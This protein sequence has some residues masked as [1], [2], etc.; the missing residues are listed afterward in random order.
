ML[1]ANTCIRYLN[2][3]SLAVVR[4]VAATPP[5]EVCL[6]SVVKGEIWYGARRSAD[7]EGNRTRQ[8]AFFAQ[9]ITLP[10]DD[11]AAEQYS[12]LRA[13]LAVRGTPI[14]PNDMMIAAIALA[15]ALTLVTHNTTEFSRVRGLKLDDW[16]L[17]A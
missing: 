1:D 6:C 7:P 13:D 9:F 4:R 10:Y 5:H 2:G 11:L 15:H 3:R 14:G 8:D 12:A 16:E 17:E